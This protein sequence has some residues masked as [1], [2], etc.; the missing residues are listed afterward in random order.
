MQPRMKG[1]RDTRGAG[2]TPVRLR[3]AIAKGCAAAAHFVRT[4]HVADRDRHLLTSFRLCCTNQRLSSDRTC[5]RVCSTHRYSATFQ[6]HLP[7]T[8]SACR[9]VSRV[10]RCR[11][12][13]YSQLSGNVASLITAAILRRN[14]RP[15]RR[16]EIAGG[17]LLRIMLSLQGLR[18]RSGTTRHD[19]IKLSYLSSKKRRE[20][21]SKSPEIGHF[22]NALD[23]IPSFRI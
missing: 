7:T 16:R 17:P 2:L 15:W 3:T 9:I 20:T 18:S 12:G 4:Q 22:W 8:C 11:A 1:G 19:G 14:V 21:E 5:D 23:G 10:R 6:V 13:L